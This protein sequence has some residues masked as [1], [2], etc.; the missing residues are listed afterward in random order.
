MYR[1]VSEEETSSSMS[2]LYS[3]VGVLLSWYLVLNFFFLHYRSPLPPPPPP[4]SQLQQYTTTYFKYSYD[5]RFKHKG[6]W[7]DWNPDFSRSTRP[8]PTSQNKRRSE[9]LRYSSFCNVSCKL[10]SVGYKY[11]EGH[12]VYLLFY[13]LVLFIYI[14]LGTFS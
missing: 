9:N 5:Y 8:S 6:H 1:K 13:L 14:C 10:G 4:L 12:C 7:W 2:E 3:R 11:A